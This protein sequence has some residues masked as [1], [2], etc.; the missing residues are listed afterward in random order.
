MK[1]EKSHRDLFALLGL[2]VSAMYGMALVLSH[3]ILGWGDVLASYA[4]AWLAV[5]LVSVG[6]LAQWYLLQ[7]YRERKGFIARS[8]EG[9]SDPSLWLWFA[10]PAVLTPPFLT[11][12]TVMK[13]LVGIRL[14]FG[15]DGFFADLDA[16][17]F[18]TDPWRLTHALFG[19][20]GTRF[21]Q[22]WYVVWGGVLGFSIT[23]VPLLAPRL[24]SARFLLAMFLIWPVTGL[25]LAAAFPSAG[26][27]F[28]NVFHPDLAARF[29]P[30]RASLGQL[31]ERDSPILVSQIYLAKYWDAP[32][33]M[34]GGG[35]SAFPSVH[36]AVAVLY[37]FAGWRILLFRIAALAFATII[38]IGSIHTGYHYAVDGLATLV[39]VPV[40]WY[41]AGRIVHAVAR[42]HAASEP[43][44][45]PQPAA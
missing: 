26:P 34:K 20:W 36:V 42:R 9:L 2:I 12:F 14:G 19:S 11:A 1:L 21:L 45:A 31:L 23:L 33:A 16:A 15:W 28:V 39:I 5:D 30:L 22:F 3:G 24:Q 27:I 43:L 35:I 38:W 41:A 4:G 44:R 40:C 13:S 17:I 32:V 37:V 29:E 18:G 6:V 25:L 8:R 7:A 10:I